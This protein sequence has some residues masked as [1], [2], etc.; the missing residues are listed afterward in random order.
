MMKSDSDTTC[1][2]VYLSVLASG[3]ISAVQVAIQVGRGVDAALAHLRALRD[4]G[5]VTSV[6]LGN[7]RAWMPSE[8]AAVFIAKNKIVCEARRKN[9]Y[10]QKMARQKSKAEK[11]LAK[12]Q[13]ER[14]AFDD[15]ENSA[16]ARKS[17]KLRTNAANAPRISATAVN[18]VW[19][20]A[21]RS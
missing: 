16:F 9:L 17:H 15:L 13:A 6:R 19:Q 11:R 5:E 1:Q 2:N 21:A 4:I 12:A 8:E 7:Y 3:S 20:W 18:S 14:Q 10:A